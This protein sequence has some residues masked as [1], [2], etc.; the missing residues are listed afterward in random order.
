[1]KKA[2]IAEL[3]DHLS[4]YLDHVKGG[5]SVLVFD[6]DQPVAQI[7]PIQSGRHNTGE[8]GERLGREEPRSAPHLLAAR[9][10][11][12]SAWE[13]WSE[14]TA[15]EIVRRYA[16]RVVE[17]HPIRAADALQIGAALVAAEDNPASIAFVSLDRNLAEAAEREGF[18]VIG[19]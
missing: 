10:E 14:V 11:I 19:H 8:L 5:G 9:R 7:V 13:R 4:R 18:H 12:L 2:R 6:R 17:T 15:V 1:M 3:K 16:E